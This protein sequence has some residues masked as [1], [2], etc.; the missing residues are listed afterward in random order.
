MFNAL[1]CYSLI[2]SV[3]CH[4]TADFVHFVLN[5]VLI[6][7]TTTEKNFLQIYATLCHA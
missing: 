4:I 2:S 3:L 7:P 1:L 5:A 6:R